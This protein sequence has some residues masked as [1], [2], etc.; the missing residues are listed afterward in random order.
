MLWAWNESSGGS[1]HCHGTQL[2]KIGWPSGMGRGPGVI[3]ARNAWDG[4]DESLGRAWLGRKGCLG[5]I[6]EGLGSIF[7]ALLCQL[8]SSQPR[9]EKRDRERSAP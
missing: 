3:Y 1:L 7:L 6:G 9:A 5:E 2:A 8:K 4:V